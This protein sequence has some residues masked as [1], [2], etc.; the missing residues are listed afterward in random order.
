[1]DLFRSVAAQSLRAGGLCRFAARSRF[2]SDSWELIVESEDYKYS[3]TAA[4]LSTKII[5]V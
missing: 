3:S 4:Y 5:I 2:R 1:M